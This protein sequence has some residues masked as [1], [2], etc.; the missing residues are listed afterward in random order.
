MIIRKHTTRQHNL[1]DIAKTLSWRAISEVPK[2]IEQTMYDVLCNAYLR[3]AKDLKWIV[4][5]S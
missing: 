5:M 2:L 4:L 3:G 1:P